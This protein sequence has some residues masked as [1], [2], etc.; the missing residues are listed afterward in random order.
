MP[1]MGFQLIST[2]L[3][4]NT[5]R[6]FPSSKYLR[7]SIVNQKRKHL[8][9]TLVPERHQLPKLRTVHMQRSVN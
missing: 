2:P 8:I 5:S 7:L 6:R 1:S 4:R 9:S 3:K